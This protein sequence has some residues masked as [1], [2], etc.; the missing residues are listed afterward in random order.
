[1]SAIIFL[2]EY[3]IKEDYYLRCPVVWNYTTLY[4]TLKS[5]TEFIY[6]YPN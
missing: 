6:S 3:H 1:M 2:Q 5:I 4:K